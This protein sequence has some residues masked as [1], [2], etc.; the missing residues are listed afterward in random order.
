[1]EQ[2]LQSFSDIPRSDYFASIRTA[3]VGCGKGSKRTKIRGGSFSEA[4][5]FT[6]DY[7]VPYFSANFS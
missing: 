7:V 5:P 2:E 4:L 6:L 1:M 3:R